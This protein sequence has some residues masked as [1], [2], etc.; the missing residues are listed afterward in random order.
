MCGNA[1]GNDGAAW[2]AGKA[3]WPMLYASVKPNIFWKEGRMSR[4]ETVCGQF[5]GDLHIDVRL[6]GK[7]SA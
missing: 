6:S 5:A 1:P 7:S 3:A 2:M 4:K